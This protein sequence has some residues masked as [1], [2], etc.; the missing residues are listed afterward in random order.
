MCGSDLVEPLWNVNLHIGNRELGYSWQTSFSMRLLRPRQ[1]G[2][3]TNMGQIVLKGVPGQGS[4]LKITIS[5]R[6]TQAHSV[7]KY[8][9]RPRVLVSSLQSSVVAI[10]SVFD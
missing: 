2:A 3:Y 7:D 4:G 9:E 6:F 1:G 8:R 5:Q 10:R